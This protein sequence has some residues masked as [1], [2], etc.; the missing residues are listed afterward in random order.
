VTGSAGPDTLPGAPY[1]ID[2]EHAILPDGPV[3]GVRIAIADGLV[4]GVT[5]AASL[6]DPD[7]DAEPVTRLAGTVV[8]GFVDT[9]VHGG[10]GADFATTDLDEARRVLA[11]H[12]AHGTT[13]SFASLVT[14]DVDTLVAQLRLLAGLCD[15]GELAGIHLEGPFLATAKCGAH[16][17]ALLHS[18]VAEEIERLIEAAGGHLSM[19]TL[20][21][22]LPDALAAIDRLVAA[23]VTVAIGHTDATRDQAALGLAGGARVATHLFNAM[24]SIHHRAP[25]P[26][27]M[28]LTDPGVL[29]ELVCDGAH[30]HPDM[31]ALAI[32]AAGP[33]R[34]ALVTDAMA[35]A[36]MS[37]GDY[38][39]GALEVNVADGVARLVGADGAPGSIAG[40]T[41]TMAAALRYVVGVVGIEL[42][43]V[44]R[45]ASTTPATWHGLGGRGLIEPGARADLVVL[46]D[47]LGVRSVMKAGRWLDD[48]AL[49]ARRAATE[50]RR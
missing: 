37:D 46:G 29:V 25:G 10:G 2:C 13:T 30:V 16:D 33:D 41:L 21:P 50:V 19:I 36:G 39:I 31:L 38:R 47:D 43:Q 45:M 49:A 34:V 6:P 4:T 35:A 20:A 23:G 3:D 32:H 11:F 48:P 42:A 17:P 26:V 14:A 5:I 27:P 15:T 44:A 28:L 40:S 1:V 8:P 12:R 7:G 24:P 22:E 18:P 9:H